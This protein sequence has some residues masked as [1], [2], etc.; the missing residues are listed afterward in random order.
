MSQKPQ[1]KE[2][3]PPF[4]AQQQSKPGIESEL[5]PRP[6]Y[7]APSYKGSGKLKGK[8]LLTTSLRQLALQLH[9]P[10]KRFSDAELNEL[11]LSTRFGPL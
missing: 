10:A 1:T 7:K 3:R 8:V 2:P 9:P 4:P 6:R 11:R 5:Q